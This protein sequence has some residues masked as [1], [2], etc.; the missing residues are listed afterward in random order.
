MKLVTLYFR[1]VFSSSEF[2]CDLVWCFVVVRKSRFAM[3]MRV[4]ALPRPPDAR[5]L[6]PVEDSRWLYFQRDF[7]AHDIFMGRTI[8][9]V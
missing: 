2:V 7:F 9:I 1:L 8:L 6:F 4:A 5:V 3:I